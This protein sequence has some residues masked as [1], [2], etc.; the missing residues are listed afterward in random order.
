MI[1]ALRHLPLLCLAFVCGAAA[2]QGLPHLPPLL[3]LLTAAAVLMLTAWRVVR[4]RRIALLALAA[5]AGLTSSA[6]RAE[7]RLTNVL[8]AQWVWQDV[9]VE[10]VVQGFPEVGAQRTQFD[11]L[12]QK[13]HTAQQTLTLQVQAR[14]SDYHRDGEAST[15]FAAGNRLRFTARLRPPR[16][17]ANP[18]GF[19]YA[20]YLFA[21]NIR[22][23]GYVRQRG[24]TVLLADGSGNLRRQ[25]YERI[26]ASGARQNAL[27]AALVIGDR[28]RLSDAQWQ[29]LRHTG[30]AHLVSVSGVHIG[31][32]FF[33]AAFL[34]GGMW[35][36][37]ARLTARL[38]AMPA[39]ILLAL[40]VA[41]AYALLAGFAVPV[42]RSFFMAA[43]AAAAVFLGGVGAVYAA[44][45]LAMCIV[46]LIDPWAV[47]APG[48]YLSFLLT[49][50]VLTAV[51][52]NAGQA[53]IWWKLGGIQVMLSL[54]AIPLTLW[55]FNEASLVSPL[56]NILAVPL[57][58]FAVL[59]LALAGTFAGEW[60]WHLAGWLLEGLW[61]LLQ[62]LAVLPYAVWQPAAPPLWLF[63]LALGGGVWLL[64]PRGVPWRS[65]GALPLL[66]ML[67]WQPPVP[68][69]GAVHLTVLDVG[70][71]TAVVVQTH[72]QVLVYDTGRAFGGRILAGYLRARGIAHID[73]LII[74]HDDS[75]H[76][77]GMARLLSSIPAR[78][79]IASDGTMHCTRGHTWQ[80]DGVH[81]RLLHPPVHHPDARTENDHS[82]VLLIESAGGKRALLT[83]DIS[84]AVEEEIA[85]PADVLLVAHHGSGHSSSARFLQTVGARAA[86]ISVGRNT[87]GHPHPQVLARLTA[88]GAEIY[89]TDMHGALIAEMDDTL[90][91][92]KW[93]EVHKKYWH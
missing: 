23:V 93:R 32:I 37:S 21:H 78:R 90:K 7:A 60:C 12:V 26:A 57:V 89:R 19:D 71:G 40:P 8:P 18:H 86:L 9:S 16:S 48:F 65:A 6:V 4:A 92:T 14:L 88:A 2:L 68:A 91:L 33:I 55:F 59:P 52:S 64:L 80:Q 36:R 83:G 69:A 20:G 45:A 11:F 5:L 43:T 73:T 87:Y 10:G 63:A 49:A 35:R 75:D 42:Q 41:F 72:S 56:A 70:Q 46:V 77:G 58:G 3:P 47:L 44:L 39:A 30:T 85:T 15:L 62:W 27:I 76:R 38:P 1:A 34:L 66:A 50:A 28:S 29:V 79:V 84:S 17:S 24:D 22:L 74:S 67:L 81:F 53:P 82:C 31:M 13:I 25:L 54:V 51:R 61:W